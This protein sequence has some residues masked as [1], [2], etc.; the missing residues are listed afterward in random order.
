MPERLRDI[1]ANVAIAASMIGAA[2]CTPTPS[3]PTRPIETLHAQ[4]VTID[5]DEGL[6]GKV[7]PGFKPLSVVSYSWE[8]PGIVGTV[9]HG[10]AVKIDGNYLLTAGHLAVD[11]QGRQPGKCM[12][13]S[14]IGRTKPDGEAIKAR[15]VQ[16]AGRNNSDDDIAL[17]Q[18]EPNVFSG[19]PSVKVPETAFNP[20][21]GTVLLAGH[22]G[23]LPGGVRR[24]PDLSPRPADNNTDRD[25]SEPAAQTVRVL[26]MDSRRFIVAVVSG[27]DFSRGAKSDQMEYGSSGGEIIDP[28]TGQLVGII[29]GGQP[30]QRVADIEKQFNVKLVDVDA[31]ATFTTISIQPVDATLVTALKGTLQTIKTC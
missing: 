7:P 15:A 3:K 20:K 24:G 21:P 29:S 14:A 28:A 10:S 26:G 4:T 1:T 5:M 2:A 11:E 23:N 22:Y 6:P 18:L 30:G 25:R 19:I 9:G 16:Q 12:D 8:V 31:N 27:P 17:I 13:A